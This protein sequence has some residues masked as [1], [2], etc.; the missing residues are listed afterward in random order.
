VEQ[1]SAQLLLAHRRHELEV[2]LPQPRRVRFVL[3]QQ[4]SGEQAAQRARHLRR[5][6]GGD[7]AQFLVAAAQLGNQ[8]PP[9]WMRTTHGGIPEST[10]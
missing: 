5:H 7:R 6:P 10:I 9:A 1:R 8:R 4:R 2:V 3:H